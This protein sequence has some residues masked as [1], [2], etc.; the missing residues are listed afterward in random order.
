MKIKKTIPDWLIGIVITVLFL[1]T[2]MDRFDFTNGI[3]MKT[4]DFRARIAAPQERNPDIELVVISDE[5]LAERG[6]W[7]CQGIFWQR[8]SIIFP[9]LVPG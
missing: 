3:E 8:V 7:P 6:R 1:F 9:R 4:F 2:F 5:D